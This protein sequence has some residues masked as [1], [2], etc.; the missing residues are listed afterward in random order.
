MKI[1]CLICTKG[2]NKN[3]R[4]PSIT[5]CVVGPPTTFGRPYGL[6]NRSPI[7]PETLLFRPD[8]YQNP[9]G[10]ETPVPGEFRTS[11]VGATWQGPKK[12]LKTMPIKDTKQ[13]KEYFKS[14]DQMSVRIRL[15]SEEQSV[16]NS[17]MKEEGWENKSGYIKY[18]LF[19][20]DPNI[21]YNKIVKKKDPNEILMICAMMLRELNMYLNYIRYRYEKDMNQ[22]YL[23]QGVDIKNG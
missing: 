4:F 11:V 5:R 20:D 17:M 22:L 13:K 16:L 15:N 3:V 8:S 7:P 18:I 6:S 10:K 14:K 2:N 21:R 19:G 9:V 23:E 1:K 12:Y